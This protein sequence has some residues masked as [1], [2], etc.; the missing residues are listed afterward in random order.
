[1]GRFEVVKSVWVEKLKA[2]P[3]LLEEFGDE[4]ELN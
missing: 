3:N 1:V 2:R 4:R